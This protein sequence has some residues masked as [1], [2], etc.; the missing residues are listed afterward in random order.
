MIS[1]RSILLLT[2][3]A[4][5][6]FKSSGFEVSPVFHSLAF[7][8]GCTDES[9]CNFD[10]AATSDDGS[11]EYMSC[12]IGCMD[13]SACNYNSAALYP[14]NG[15]CDY[16]TCAG[17]LDPAACN[18]EEAAT[19]ANSAA[20][21]YSCYGCSDFTACNFDPAAEI[22]NFEDCF[23]SAPNFDCDGN[24]TGC[25]GCGP[26]FNSALNDS[27]VE[28]EGDLPLHVSEALVAI[29][30]CTEDTLAHGAFAADLREPVIINAGFTGEGVG[31]DGAVRIFGLTN[32]GLSESDYFIETNPLIL[33]RF[34]NGIATLS[35]DVVNTHNPSLKWS[36]HLTFED[37]RNASEWLSEDEANGLV[38]TYGCNLVPEDVLVYRLK[39]D[40]S[41]LIGKDGYLNSYLQLSH[42]PFNE[43]KRFQLGVG[44]NSSTCAFGFGGWFAWEGQV[45]GVPVM[46]MTGDVVIDLS[47]DGVDEV[48]CGSESTAHF[49]SAINPECGI[50]TEAV[51]FFNRLDIEPPLW[52][53]DC[54]TEIALCAPVGSLSPDIPMP[55]EAEFMDTCEEILFYSYSEL[56]SSGDS[57]NGGA[58]VLERTH[59]AEDCSGNVGV[60]V[61]TLSYD[62]AICPQ[63]VNFTT[64]EPEGFLIAEHGAFGSSSND[65][66][67]NSSNPFDLKIHPNPSRGIAELNWSGVK[68]SKDVTLDV[69]SAD[70]TTALPTILWAGSTGH[71]QRMTLNGTSLPSGTYFV[72]IR[73]HRNY[74]VIPWMIID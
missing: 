65:Y 3:G 23:Y 39:A 37:A 53:G 1:L 30:S 59:T 16:Q 38:S 20:C 46:G 7:V 44:A 11:C 10:A 4:L 72:R 71:L 2:V 45:L 31:T 6:T 5:L 36:V 19:I 47:A 43:N 73:S 63:Q 27:T 61:Q 14:N 13:E 26:V 21:N 24:P 56:I 57:T 49:Y 64:S 60:F 35:G 68:N 25:F 66:Q 54:P 12:L 48:A 55:C 40:Q 29:E 22:V 28:C 62:G 51:Q 34:S 33:T 32:L 18:F 17:C 42:M 8:S 15:S 74:Q 9:A 41:F 69:Y 50:L 67:S 52:G 58:F 70:G